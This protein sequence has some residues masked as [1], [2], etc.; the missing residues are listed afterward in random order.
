MILEERD[1][2][3]RYDIRWPDLVEGILLRRYKRFIAD[4]RLKDGQMVSVH[5][6]NS[7][8]MRG[9]SEPGRRVYLSVHNSSHRKFPYTWE[10]IDMGTSLVG[11]NTIVPNHLVRK[12]VSKGKIKGLTGYETI[13][14]EVRYATGT[15][16]DLLLKGDARKCF[17]EVKNCTL[18]EYNTAYFPDAITIRGLRHLRDLQSAVR[19]GYR[20]VIFFLIQRMDATRFAP[21]DHIDPEYGKELTKALS[22]GVEIMAYDVHLD[23]IGISIRRP[24]PWRLD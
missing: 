19:R 22:N 21:A 15:R 20:A 16:F 7:G 1:S 5:C 12:A 4:V 6:P 18:V 10:L 3:T 8:S 11:I 13:D 23:L 14:T 24:V 2:N 17:V 9:C